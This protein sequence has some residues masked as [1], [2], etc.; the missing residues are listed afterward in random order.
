MCTASQTPECAGKRE[1]ST[2]LN[3]II[4]AIQRALYEILGWLRQMFG[5]VAKIVVGH[6]IIQIS[7][8]QKKSSQ[9]NDDSLMTI[10]LFMSGCLTVEVFSF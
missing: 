5:W 9:E 10:D 1:L 7:K 2:L 4:I 6:N 8:Q 3:N